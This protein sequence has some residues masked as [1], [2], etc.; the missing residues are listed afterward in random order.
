MATRALGPVGQVV[1][2]SVSEQ[3]LSQIERPVLMVGP[4]VVGD[5]LS[6]SPTLVIGVGDGR[7]DDVV[8]AAVT[9]WYES[10]GGPRPWVVEVRSPADAEG[11]DDLPSLRMEPITKRLAEEGIEADCTV[12]HAKRAAD[13]LIEA[14]DRV[15]D[16]VLV[17]A[18][19]RWT[20]PDGAHLTSTGR[21]SVQLA[22][23]PVLVVPSSPVLTTRR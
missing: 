4:R 15:A 16:A 10:F 22:H 18:S 11:D 19:T 2:G 17:L 7:V 9:S 21:R 6:P 5:A 8:V 23:H 3:V 20:D 14:A 12:M 13:G 1:L